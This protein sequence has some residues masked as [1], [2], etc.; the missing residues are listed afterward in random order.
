MIYLAEAAGYE[1]QPRLK[2]GEIQEDRGAFPRAVAAAASGAD[3]HLCPS[4][5]A[6]I[7]FKTPF[8]FPQQHNF[9][10]FRDY[11]TFQVHCHLQAGAMGTLC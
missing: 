9:D 8:S 4:F 5:C 1:F 6:P 7:L 3:L 2:L 11:R 10:L